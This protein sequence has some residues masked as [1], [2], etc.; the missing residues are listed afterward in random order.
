MR[1]YGAKREDVLAFV[2]SKQEVK[3]SANFTRQLQVW[4]EVGYQV[5]E[6]EERTFPKAPYRAFLDDRAALLYKRKGAHR[7]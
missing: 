4:E 3:P 1:K 2:Q 6:D 5:W 7:K